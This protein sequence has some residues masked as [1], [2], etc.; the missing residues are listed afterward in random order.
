MI[1]ESDNMGD[2]TEWKQEMKIQE[3]CMM[4]KAVREIYFWNEVADLWN[5]VDSLIQNIF[6][7]LNFVQ[8]KV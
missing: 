1:K 2:D 6:I 5:F 8:S 3:W 7:L 4:N